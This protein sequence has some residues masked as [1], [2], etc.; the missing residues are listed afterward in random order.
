MKTKLIYLLA[1]ILVAGIVLAQNDSCVGDTCS[2]DEGGYTYEDNLADPLCWYNFN[3][4][5]LGY[6]STDIG[7]DARGLLNVLKGANYQQAKELNE[8]QTSLQECKDSLFTA[9]LSTYVLLI[10]AIILAI[11]VTYIYFKNTERR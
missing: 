1:I 9:K 8:T 11:F 6:N 4:C 2:T 10:V 5:N 3:F 7:S